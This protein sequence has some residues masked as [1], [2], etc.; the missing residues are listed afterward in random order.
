MVPTPVMGGRMALTG[1]S[2]HG[3]FDHVVGVPPPT[4]RWDS[5]SQQRAQD[6]VGWLQPA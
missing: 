5:D 4:P 3:T 1:Q 2:E 6:A